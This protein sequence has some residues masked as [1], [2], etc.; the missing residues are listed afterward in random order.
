MSGILCK[1]L[2]PLHSATSLGTE[3]AL[4]ECESHLRIHTKAVAET[5]RPVS[6]R[7]L[8]AGNFFVKRYTPISTIFV[9]GTYVYACSG[10]PMITAPRGV[11]SHLGLPDANSFSDGFV[12]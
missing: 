4:F 9:I 6:V 12:A 10:I 2:E 1:Q 7:G 8:D 5:I 3:R 11:R